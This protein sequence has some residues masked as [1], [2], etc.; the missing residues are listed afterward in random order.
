MSIFFMR[1]IA[2]IARSA[3][4]DF[5]SRKKSSSILGTTC[6]ESP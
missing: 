4:G 1:S 2:S 5:S 6:H 3:P